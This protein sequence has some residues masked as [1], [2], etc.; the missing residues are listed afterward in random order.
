MST[1][2]E[3][4]GDWIRESTPNDSD[5]NEDNEYG[6]AMNDW[7]DYSSDQA[8]PTPAPPVVVQEES[9]ESV[10]EAVV[11]VE[12]IQNELPPT[13]EE[14]VVVPVDEIQDE[15]P[16]TVEEEVVEEQAETHVDEVSEPQTEPVVDAP[17]DQPVEVAPADDEP[18]MSAVEIVEEASYDEAPG[19]DEDISAPVDEAPASDD[20]VS[21]PVD[22]APAFDDEPAL[23]RAVTVDEETVE[24]VEEERPRPTPGAVWGEPVPEV[25]ETPEADETPVAQE[26]P[27]RVLRGSDFGRPISAPI[28]ESPVEPEPVAEVAEL[29]QELPELGHATEETAS[30]A[31]NELD[32]IFRGAAAGAA[33]QAADAVETTAVID[34]EIQRRL[35]AERIEEE[36]RA[37]E[38]AALREERNARLGVVSTSPENATRPIP[39][40]QKLVTDKFFGSFGLFVLRLV[41]AG[42]VGVV[43]YQILSD[44]DATAAFLGQTLLPEPRLSAWIVGFTLGAIAVLLVI[45]MLVRVAGLLLLVIAGASLAFIRWGAFNIFVPGLEGFLGDRDLLMAAVALLFLSLGGGRWGIDGAFRKARENAREARQ[46]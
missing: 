25:D 2:Q 3:R 19:S 5:W 28:M 35:E 30:L 18:V 42:I 38:L 40:K 4:S 21:A 34:P 23:P 31:A 9:E 37:M 14:E 33:P 26:E 8:D 32:G 10:E 29:T 43:G 6:I 11:P 39:P 24:A 46:A 45:G 36:R 1:N 44:V 20:E 15:L 12:E 22:E 7:D 41:V 16:P 27:E 13:V 17:A